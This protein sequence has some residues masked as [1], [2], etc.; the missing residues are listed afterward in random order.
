MLLWIILFLIVIAISAVLA[1]NSIKDWQE[2]PKDFNLAYSLYLIQKVENLTEEIIDK[3]YLATSSNHAIISFE[4]LLKGEKVALVVFGPVANLRPYISALELL[5]LEDFSKKE[6]EGQIRAWEMGLK[7][8]V[9]TLKMDKMWL[10]EK[11]HLEEGEQFWWQIILQ[12][13][14]K[15][16]NLFFAAELRAVLLAKDKKRAD[17]LEKNLCRIGSTVGLSILPQI[18]SASQILKFYSLRSMPHGHAPINVKSCE[19]LSLLSVK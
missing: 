5:E 16:N 8:P 3:L 11:P 2:T 19:I 9:P 10:D 12:P 15:K 18:Y 13:A 7:N 17:E 14:S 6:I 4:R 1:Y